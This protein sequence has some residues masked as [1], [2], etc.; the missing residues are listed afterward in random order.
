LGSTLFAYAIDQC[1]ATNFLDTGSWFIYQC[2]MDSTSSGISVTKTQ[3]FDA[4][5]ATDGI[6]V[7]TFDEANM[8]EGNRGSFDCSGYNTYAKIRVSLDS[9]CGNTVTIYSAL[10]ACSYFGESTQINVYC[11]DNETIA[12]IFNLAGQM[13]TS[14]FLPSSTILPTSF[15]ATLPTLFN[16]TLPQFNATLPQLNATLSTFLNST[17]P[18]LF[19]ATLPGFN[20]TLPSMLNMTTTQ[21]MDMLCADEAFCDKWIFSMNQCKQLATIPFTT[22]PTVIYGIMDE[23][24]TDIMVSSTT[25][26]FTTSSLNISGTEPTLPTAGST[27][28]STSTSTGVSSTSTTGSTITTSGAVR[29]SLFFTFGMFFSFFFL[30]SV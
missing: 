26:E 10:G 9:D 15:N 13:P 8:T 19:N 23:C 27:S 17:L 24:N 1:T 21:L 2:D 3:Y 12:Q 25:V 4:E 6:I 11:S 14:T 29:P 7:E 5:C 20:A 18:T 28:T 22:T 16:A 30:V